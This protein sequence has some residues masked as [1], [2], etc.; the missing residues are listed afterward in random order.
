MQIFRSLAGYSLGRADIVRRAMSKKKHDVME[1]E[2]EIFLHGLLNDDGSVAVPGCEKNGVPARVAEDIFNEMESF[3]S[4]AFN[5]PHAAAYATISYRTAWLKCYYPREYLAALLT[6][7]LD[8]SNKLSSYIAECTRLNIQVLPPDVNESKLGFNVSGEDIRF[9]LLAIRNLGRGV[10][11]KILEERDK[12]GNFNTFYN[13]CKRMF[14][15]LNRRALES[16]VKSGALDGLDHNRREMLEN[17]GTVLDH[18]EADRK[19]NVEGQIGFFDLQPAGAQED[20]IIRRLPDYSASDKLAYEKEVTGMFLSG[21]PMAEYASVYGKIRVAKIGDLLDEE[22]A[23]RYPD[24]K[25][26]TVLGILVG[27][28]MKV[29]KNNSTMAFL[30]L[31][32]MFGAVEV[33]VF[34]KILGEYG[35]YMVEGKIIRLTGRISRREDEETKLVCSQVEEA[36]SPQELLQKKTDKPAPKPQK[37]PGLYLKVPGEQ[38]KEYEQAKKLLAVFDGMTP[39]YVYMDDTKKLM[40][41]PVSLRVDVNEVLLREL[42]KVLGEK[43][44]A[45]V[46]NE[47]Q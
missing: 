15:F 42:K 22:Q 43:N 3:A 14:E 46:Q 17:V 31:E 35:Q 4:Y 23:D 8:N 36:G 21:H 10:I 6:S 26:E 47:Q 20:F 37:R 44:V 5:K 19:R 40:M 28:K 1:R 33:L 7:V 34:P 9:G 25:M 2:K 30:T 16:L 32:D 27:I 24:G 18:L 29:T 13:F 12:A 39:L 11:E 38:S 45:V 41:A